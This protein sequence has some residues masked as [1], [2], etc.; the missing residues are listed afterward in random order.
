[1]LRR[2]NSRLIIILIFCFYSCFCFAQTV[3]R[4]IIFPKK[5]GDPALI[6]Y[7]SIKD[8]SS[9]NFSFKYESDLS[10]LIMQKSSRVLSQKIIE[11]NTATST[12]DLS[13]FVLWEQMLNTRK[14]LDSEIED[15]LNTNI[16]SGTNELPYK[17]PFHKK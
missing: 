2:S 4:Y 14:K 12:N 13:S 7:A 9:L 17:K 16:S 15:S 5:A 3:K 10:K 11:E 6:D 8:S 1:M